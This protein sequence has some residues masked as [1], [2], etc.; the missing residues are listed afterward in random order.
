[1]K[2][3]VA[4]IAFPFMLAAAGAASAQQ[5]SEQVKQECRQ[6]AR[7]I[8]R[9]YMDY[10]N[11]GVRNLEAGVYKASTNWGEQVAIYMAQAATRSD[12]IT[13]NELTTLGTAYCV[14]RR[15]T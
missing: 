14:E 5:A 4:G 10:K 1:M 9:I 8:A 11:R 3:I 15:P 7:E 6:A 12:S 13:E 2:R